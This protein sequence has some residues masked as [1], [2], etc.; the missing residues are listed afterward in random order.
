MEVDALINALQTEGP[1]GLVAALHGKGYFKR[2]GKGKGLGH[3]QGNFDSSKGKGKGKKGNFKG[4]Y[5]GKG[6]GKSGYFKSSKGKGQGKTSKGGKG[7]GLGQNTFRPQE[8]T[9]NALEAD[10]VSANSGSETI[11]WGT[12]APTEQESWDTSTFWYD[13]S[14]EEPYCSD[15]TQDGWVS[16]LSSD[17]DVSTWYDTAWDT[18]GDWPWD[19]STS[20]ISYPST[21]VSAVTTAPPGLE[22]PKSNPKV[23]FASSNSTSGSPTVNAVTT[24][25]STSTSL[26]PR[27]NVAGLLGWCHDCYFHT[28]SIHSTSATQTKH[29]LVIALCF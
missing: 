6:K 18:S 19:D 7:K 1:D 14:W 10:S 27:R 15:W 17:W 9:V 20:V 13:E 16:H 21:A 28:W 22:L 11:Q 24:S 29:L 26:Q 25:T 2:K 5:K 8:K 4:T 23:T 3:F 12:S